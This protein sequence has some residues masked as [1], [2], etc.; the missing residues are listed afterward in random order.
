MPT[1]PHIAPVV[2]IRSEVPVA[3]VQ[4]AL[5]LDL[6]PRL[7]PPSVPPLRRVSRSDVVPV[8]EEVRSRL[9]TWARRYLQAAVEIAVGDR[10]VSQVL[11][12][13]TPDVYDDLA[14]RAQLVA[15]AAGTAPGAGRGAHA[16]RPA[17][18]G[19]RT[20]FV[21]DDAL[22]ACAHVRYGRRSRAVAARFELVRG[23]WQCV[24]LE[25]A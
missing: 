25:F 3:T 18:V 13:T 8:A 17:V 19:G 24:A 5:A 2:P 6:A 16:V 1:E 22:E 4:G 12:W 9:D 21:R 23:R 10:P 14:R 20:A 7:D 11:R 15:R